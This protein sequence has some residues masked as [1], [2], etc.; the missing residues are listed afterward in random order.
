MGNK[1]KVKKG[2]KGKTWWTK[3]KATKKKKRENKRK[4]N[5]T[6]LETQPLYEFFKFKIHSNK[7]FRRT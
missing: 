7:Q 3:T 1:W 5:V 2:K 6:T 4:N